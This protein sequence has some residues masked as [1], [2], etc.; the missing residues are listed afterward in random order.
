MYNVSN[1]KYEYLNIMN[2][3]HSTGNQVKWKK[4]GIKDEQK[5]EDYL[6]IISV[7]ENPWHE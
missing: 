2:N 6:E 4:L 1:T 7:T 5:F 3:V